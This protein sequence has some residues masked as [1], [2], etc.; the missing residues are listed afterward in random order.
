MSDATPLPASTTLVAPIAE[1]L[2]VPAEFADAT[3]EM[4]RRASELATKLD[5]QNSATL[6]SFGI[7]AQKKLTAHSETMLANVRNADSGAAGET[8]STLMLQFKGLKLDQLQAA[9]NPLKNVFLFL[10]SPLARFQQRFETVSAQIAE[11]VHR[12]EGDRLA[13]SRDVVS[14]DGLFLASL[15]QYKELTVYI[16]AG[17]EKLAAIDNEFLPALKRQAEESKSMLD[18]QSYRDAQNARNELDRRL[19]NLRLTK[20]AT[21]QSLP[22]IR[23]IQDVNKSLVDKIQTSIITTIPIWKQQIAMAITLFRQE[24]A[25]SHEKAVTDTTNE[26][27]RQNATL[28]QTQNRSAREQVERGVIDL[29]TLRQV[30]DSLLRTIEDTVR[31]SEEAKDKRIAA[32]REMSGLE[33]TLKDALRGASAPRPA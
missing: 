14:L 11:T 33:T 9:K 26:L 20:T 24:K 4:R 28:L 30:N 32:A 7:D 23:L 1:T 18:A 13:L 19:H 6:L 27:L 17:E 3:P 15:D 25:L 16:L 2:R 8:L 10:A 5:W 31:I 22:Q 21:L 12:L 29:E